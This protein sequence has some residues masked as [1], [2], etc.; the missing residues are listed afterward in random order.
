MPCVGIGMGSDCALILLAAME[1]DRSGAWDCM[2]DEEDFEIPR[3]V[4]AKEET[5]KH[6]RRTSDVMR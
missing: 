5:R 6:R 4:K 3:S 1:G 2:L